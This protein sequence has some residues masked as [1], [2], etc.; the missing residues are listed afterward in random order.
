[1]DAP[2]PGFGS[3]GEEISLYSDLLRELFASIRVK[4]HT[5]VSPVWITT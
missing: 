5:H 3:L 4:P 2:I 1:M